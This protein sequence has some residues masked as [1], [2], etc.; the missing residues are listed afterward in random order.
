MSGLAPL[1][2][3]VVG[4]WTGT[5]AKR[6]LPQANPYH[7]SR[8]TRAT[9]PR[10]GIQSLARDDERTRSERHSTQSPSMFCRLTFHSSK[11]HS[12]CW[13]SRATVSNV[14]KLS[15]E[16]YLGKDHSGRTKIM[17]WQAKRRS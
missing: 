3:S 16:F 6:L 4:Q 15:E 10:G 13:L 11:Q 2:S 1:I 8:N 17:I 14:Q 12:V 9:T 5:V 7:C